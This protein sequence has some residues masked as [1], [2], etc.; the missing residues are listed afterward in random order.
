MEPEF[1]SK[2]DARPVGCARNV[3]L[4]DYPLLSAVARRDLPLAATA[5]LFVPLCRSTRPVTSVILT[6][7]G[8]G[9]GLFLFPT[10]HTS[11][12]SRKGIAITVRF[13]PLD[14]LTASRSVSVYPPKHRLT[15]GWN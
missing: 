12:F 9:P 11:V 6:G 8:E 5:R 4:K 10:R 13:S 14:R 7:C 2:V 1:F 3:T 15:I